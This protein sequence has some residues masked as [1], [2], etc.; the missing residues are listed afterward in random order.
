MKGAPR[1]DPAAWGLGGALEPLL[2]G[3]RNQVF[4]TRFH[5]F[6]S[7]RR[8]E[9]SLRWLEPLK[10]VARQAGLVVPGL[11]PSRSG[12]LSVDGW[13]CEPFVAM[14]AAGQDAD[15]REARVKMGQVHRTTL[16]HPQRPGFVSARDV[17]GGVS[18]GD[19][20]LSAVPQNLAARLRE[21]LAALPKADMSAIHGDLGLGN[22]GRG[23]N[24]GLVLFDWDE[25]RVDDP[26]FDLEALDEVTRQA[27]LAWEILCSWQCE[28]AY[29]RTLAETHLRLSR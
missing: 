14:S 26:I 13:T 16:G 25:A 11:L 21:S 4:H 23:A 19:V 28:P 3:H 2:G 6:K 24:G 18:G 15:L 9:A 7:T 1:P 29:A 22:L 12:A 27:K 17:V 8:N 5:V 10:A 20:D